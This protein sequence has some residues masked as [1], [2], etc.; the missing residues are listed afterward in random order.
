MAVASVSDKGRLNRN[1]GE[2]TPWTGDDRRGFG[3]TAMV[4]ETYSQTDDVFAVLDQLAGRDKPVIL[5]D[6]SRGG[7]IAIGAANLKHHMIRERLSATS[8]ACGFGG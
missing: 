8:I 1:R 2:T 6:R 5:V 7:G 3:E 4:D